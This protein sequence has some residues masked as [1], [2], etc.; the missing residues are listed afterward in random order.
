M[1]RRA[2]DLV[3]TL[4]LILSL[5]AL[6]FYKKK[7][8]YFKTPRLS[9]KNSLDTCDGHNRSPEFKRPIYQRLS[10]VN[11]NRL[12]VPNNLNLNAS[13][14]L[15]LPSLLSLNQENDSTSESNSSVNKRRHRPH[16]TVSDDGTAATIGVTV[17]RYS[18]PNSDGSSFRSTSSSS[19][20][21]GAGAKL[22]RHNATRQ[23]VRSTIL[24]VRSTAAEVDGT[25]GTI[26]FIRKRIIVEPRLSELPWAGYISDNRKLG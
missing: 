3:A 22:R 11:D 24:P 8:R 18:T 21:S 13:T 10:S 15:S 6:L 7:S 19:G 4:Y 26:S 5:F 20:G 9:L 17:R 16:S 23:K 1:W 14:A 2:V 12:S 25:V